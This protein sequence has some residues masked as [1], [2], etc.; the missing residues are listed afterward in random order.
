MP[1]QYDNTNKGAL[2]PNDR[3]SK[4][5]QPDYKGSINIEGVEY[6]ISGW[7][8]DTNRGTIVSMSAE[9]KDQNGQQ[10]RIQQQSTGAR[11]LPGARPADSGWG[12]PPS[13]NTPPP[14]NSGGQRDPLEAGNRTQSRGEPPMDFDDDIPF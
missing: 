7:L 3:K 12:N 8:K 10:P 2:F 11:T 1:Q 4:P 14:N 13:N 5:N 9:P 6:W